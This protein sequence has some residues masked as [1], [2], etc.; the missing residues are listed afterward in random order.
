MF[1]RAGNRLGGATEEE[2][3]RAVGLPP[4][5]PELR[6]GAGELEAAEAGRLPRLVEESDLLGDLHVHSR[7]SSD[8]RS[9]LEELAAAARALGRRDLAITDH[10]RSR[11]LG[12]DAARASQQA[13]AVRALDA[14]LGGRPRLLAGIEVDILPDGTLDLP[15]AALSELD[16][17]V[18]AVHARLADPAPRNTERIVRA[19][20]SGV[21]H[22]LGHPTGRQL[23]ARDAYGLDLDAVLEAARREGVALEVNAMPERL[24]LT[25]V[26]CRAAKA[27]GVPVVI[28]TDAH[29]AAHLANLRYGVWVARR[30]WLEAKDVL[31]TLP[32]AELRRRLGREGAPVR[33]ARRR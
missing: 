15:D 28:S 26:G 31:N 5:P 19:L 21:V 22:V 9:T 7:G 24:D 25:D 18:A 14:R 23:G 3:Y 12:L 17:V 27:A 4:I 6:E 16:C 2:V 32:V 30:G 11:P 8:G 10:S 1:D 29:D 13:A 20:R 33:H